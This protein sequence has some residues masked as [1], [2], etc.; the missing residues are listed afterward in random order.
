[1]ANSSQDS[2]NTEESLR[3]DSESPGRLIRSERWWTKRQKLLEDAG[4]MLRPRFRQGWTPSW[5]GTNKLYFTLEDG[6]R[7]LLRVA[8][9]ATRISDGKPVM[10]KQVV[11]EEGP[12]ELDIATFLSSDELLSDP[13]N[14][15]VPLLEVIELP[16]ADKDKLMVMPRLRPFHNPK[17]ETY[18]EAVSFMTQI[19]EGLQFMHERNIAHRDCTRNNIMLDPSSM[20]PDSFHPRKINRRK[21]FKGKAKHYTRTHCRPRYYYIDFG[22]SRRYDP[23]KG[24]PLDEPLEGGD[25]S[26][27]EHRDQSKRCNPFFTDIYYLGNLIRET[28][29]YKRLGFE[30]VEPLVADMVQDDPEKR[31]KIDEVVTRFADIRSSLSTKKLR[32]RIVRRNEVGVVRFWRACGYLYRTAG[33]ILSKKPPIPDP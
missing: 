1:M 9:D 32:S 19:F 14:H 12:Y 17:F 10:L 5:K 16:N 28:F 7:N 23:V 6:L 15:T 30:F 31:P 24:P 26:A 20:Y 11:R 13:R 8:L 21:N 3:A 22:L 33:Y 4:Y 2:L 27:P 18:G 25:K 29:I